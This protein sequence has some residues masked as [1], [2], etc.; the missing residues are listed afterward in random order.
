MTMFGSGGNQ[1]IHYWMLHITTDQPVGC[2]G[3]NTTKLFNIGLPTMVCS[4]ERYFPCI[5][6]SSQTTEWTSE[7]S[8]R[9]IK[10]ADMYDVVTTLRIPH[11]CCALINNETTHCSQLFIIILP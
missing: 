7:G 5:L 8:S 1:A 11:V 6:A 9:K 2:S 10:I 3:Q 4:R